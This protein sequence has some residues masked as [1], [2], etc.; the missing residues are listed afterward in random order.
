MILSL[1]L[2]GGVVAAAVSMSHEMPPPQHHA[3]APVTSSAKSSDEI[4]RIPSR[5]IAV[6]METGPYLVEEDNHSG[7]LAVCTFSLSSELRT[8]ESVSLLAGN[9]DIKFI[10]E[11]PMTIPE[12]V[13]RTQSFEEDRIYRASIPSP[14]Q[15]GNTETFPVTRWLEVP[16]KK[17]L[18]PQKSQT[19]EIEFPVE[20]HPDKPGKKSW[21]D[22]E[23]S[24][25]PF[26][27]YALLTTQSGRRYL[28]EIV[29]CPS[30]SGASSA[31]V[32]L[33][34]LNDLTTDLAAL[35][36]E[37]ETVVK[38]LHNYRRIY[39][40]QEKAKPT[41]AYAYW[42]AENQI[43]LNGN[44]TLSHV[45]KMGDAFCAYYDGEVSGVIPGTKFV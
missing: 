44:L 32:F 36:K 10:E 18:P 22:P 38:E 41:Y 39:S 11:I 17:A 6:A 23:W 16:V 33:R 15:I 27:L 7:G 30:Q 21:E 31:E 19:F 13:S 40:S 43:T 28:Q 3:Q 2:C 20:I 29:L 34:D 4:H 37:P 24:T 35:E 12:Y 8:S 14:E 1:L 5:Q 42:D 25:E 45:S 9:A 26:S